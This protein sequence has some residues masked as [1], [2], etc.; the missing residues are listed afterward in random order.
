M[1]HAILARAVRVAALALSALVLALPAAGI[2]SAALTGG[3]AQVIRN[4]ACEGYDNA[5]GKTDSSGCKNETE[6]AGF[7]KA[8]EAIV[9]PAV[10]AMIA[11]TPIA[12]LYGAGALMFGGRRGLLIIGTSLGTLVFLI[13]VKGIVA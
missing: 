2:A 5:K 4:A 12:C 1:S 9:N 7:V 3:G 13:S 6:L 10:I 11:I 8:A